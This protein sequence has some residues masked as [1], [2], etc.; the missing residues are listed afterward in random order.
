MPSKGRM[1]KFHVLRKQVSS[2]FHVFQS[3]LSG[4][5]E[6]WDW[7]GEIH[8][9]WQLSHNCRWG[10]HHAIEVD[11]THDVELVVDKNVMCAKVAVGE[12]E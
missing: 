12:T 5:D 10:C 6:P 3:H 1:D 9:L 2:L 4:F 11:E 7:T 8:E